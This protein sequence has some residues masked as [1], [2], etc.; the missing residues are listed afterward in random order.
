MSATLGELARLVEG[1]LVGEGSIEVLGAATLLDAGRGDITFVDRDEKAEKLA[2]T[3]ARAAIVPA[4]FPADRLTMPA[5]AVADVHQAFT[6]I[7]QYFRPARSGGRLGISPRAIVSPTARIAEDVDIHAAPR[8][9]RR[10]TGPRD[11]HPLRH[12]RHGRLPIGRRSDALSQA[13]C[14]T[15]T[16]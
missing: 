14:C 15:R 13:W 8:R 9:R 10:G 11:D 7:V 3:H 6:Q 2:A 12:P 4:G 1:R 5:I 16:R